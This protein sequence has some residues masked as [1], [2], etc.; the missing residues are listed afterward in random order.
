MGFPQKTFF[1]KQTDFFSEIVNGGEFAVE[2]AWF[3]RF[4]WKCDFSPNYEV[5][6]PKKID[7]R[8]TVNYGEEGVLIREKTF[9]TF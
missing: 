5:F 3:A 4:F 1:Q 8:K 2:C 9:S 6:S 7:V